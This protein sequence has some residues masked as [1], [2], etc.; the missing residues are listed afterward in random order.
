MGSG[1]TRAS[2]QSGR[3]LATAVE[4]KKRADRIVIGDV[5]RPPVGGR[6][7]D[8]KCTVRVVEPLGPSVV[9]IRQRAFLKGIIDTT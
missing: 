2:A 7:G 5:G 1:C 6:D 9:E 3:R 8:V 4:F